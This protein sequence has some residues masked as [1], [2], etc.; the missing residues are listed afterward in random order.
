MGAVKNNSDGFLL[1]DKPCGPSSFTIV[2]AVR[3]ALT[4]KK[5]GHAG[6]LD[7]AASGLLVLAVGPATRLLPYLPLEPKVYRFSVRFGSETDTLDSEGVVVKSG[8]RVPARD[9]VEAILVEFTGKQQQ[10]PP[11]FSAIKVNGERSYARARKGETVELPAREIEIFLLQ[12]LQFDETPG[13]AELEVTCSGG[14]YVR[15][16]ARD[17]AAKLGTCGYAIAIRRMNIGKFSVESAVPFDKIGEKD[18]SL[19]HAGEALSD[20]PRIQLNVVQI[21]KIATGSDILC[22]PAGASEENLPEILFGYNN[23]NRLF[24]VLKL[25]EGKKYHP[26]KK[27]YIRAPPPT[28]GTLE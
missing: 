9:E 8:G 25:V 28:V 3:R 24:A 13:V 18:F 11:C 4:V 15:S 20:F 1:I 19:M 7:P 5:T 12:L 2:A 16:L 17:L 23:T 26:E 27:L 14:T 21:E 10:I 22:D 6:T